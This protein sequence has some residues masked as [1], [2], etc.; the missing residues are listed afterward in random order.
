MRFVEKIYH[1]MLIFEK[2]SLPLNKVNL[3]YF[4]LDMYARANA[5]Y[6]M[7]VVGSGT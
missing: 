5:I 6:G 1:K 7:M 3:F 2:V 4:G